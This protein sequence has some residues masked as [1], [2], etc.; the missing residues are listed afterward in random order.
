MLT[1]TTEKHVNRENEAQSVEGPINSKPH[2][3]HLKTNLEIISD[4]FFELLI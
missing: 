1:V 4:V 2:N 3:P